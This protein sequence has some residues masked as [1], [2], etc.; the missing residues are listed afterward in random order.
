MV[1]LK[2]S[3]LNLGRFEHDVKKVDGGI[4]VDGHK[5]RIFA[6]K[7]PSQIKWGDS[8]SD[9]VCESTGA[10]TSKDKAG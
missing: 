2:F 1:I 6:E 7:D 9:Y 10:F 8:G 3:L 4:S 5:V